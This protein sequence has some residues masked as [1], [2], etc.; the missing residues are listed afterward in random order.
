[1]ENKL[2]TKK[3]LLLYDQS[4]QIN[5]DLQYVLENFCGTVITDL[6]LANGT[7][8]AILYMC[9]DTSKFVINYDKFENIRIIKELS[10]N[11][12]GV[13]FNYELISVG[14]IP[15]NIYNVGVYF[16]RYFDSPDDSTYYNRIVNEHQFQS[17]TE[18][19]KPSSAFR[20]G[21]YLTPVTKKDDGIHFKL[22]RCSTNLS[23]PTDNFRSTDN[24]IVT[25]VNNISRSLFSEQVELNHVLAQTYHNLTDTK[26]RKAKISEHSDK[27]KD[28]PK[29]GIMAFCS[30]YNFN[31]DMSNISRDEFDYCYKNTSIL[32]RLRFRLKKEAY[33]TGLCHKFDIT[34]YP[35][36]VFLMPL[37]TNRLYTH[38]IIPSALPIDKI[39]TR[40]GYVIR[41]SSTEALFAN[42]QTFIIKDGISHPLEEPTD[43]GVARLKSLYYKENSTIENISYDGFYFSLNRGDYTMPM[44]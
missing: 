21:I 39:P 11:Y 27:T 8:D 24:E 26:E 37:S 5:E 40:M 19:N 9:G 1:M 42:G 20:K 12:D 38:E 31:N 10:I 22:L 2:L 4:S 41:C 43:K 7:N 25:A 34:L 44:L 14:Q 33:D 13:P 6:Q 32:T 28:M 16:R 3:H 15:I 30:F 36:S 18:S 35:N 23:G 29:N 17:L